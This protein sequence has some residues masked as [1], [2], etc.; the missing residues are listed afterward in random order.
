MAIS[1]SA[2]RAGQAYVELLVKDSAFL[3]GLNRA[4]SALKRLGARLNKIGQAASRAGKDLIKMGVLG[5]TPI[6]FAVRRFAQFDD[7]MRE[8]QAVTQATGEDFEKLTALAKELGRTTSFTAV[9]VAAGMAEMGRMGFTATEILEGIPH[10][11]NLARATTTEVGEAAEIAGA[12]LRG[13]GLDASQ[14]A[15]VADVLTTAANKSAQRLEDIGE[16][17]KYVAP[18]AITA[19]ASIEDTAAALAV[20]ANYGVRGTIAGT[21]LRNAYIRLTETKGREFLEQMGIAATN[22]DGSLRKLTDILLDLGDATANLPNADRIA[23]FAN[24]LG[25]RALIGGL[26][27]GISRKKLEEMV[28]IFTKTKDAARKT[29]EEM[30]RG[31]GGAIRRFL[32]AFEGLG[33]AVGDAMDKVLQSV[34]K[35]LTGTLGIITKFVNENQSL[36]VALGLGFVSAIALGAGLVVLGYAFIGLGGIVTTVAATFAAIASVIGFMLTP[37]GA[38]TVGFAYLGYQVIKETGVIGEASDHLGTKFDQLKMTAFRSFEGIKSALSSG[39]FKAAAEIAMLGMEVAW[40]EGTKELRDTWTGFTLDINAFFLDSLYSIQIG[41][42]KFGQFFDNFWAKTIARF[43]TDWNDANNAVAKGWTYVLSLLD[44]SIDVEAV[45]KRLDR[46]AQ[47]S[48]ENIYAEFDK[49]AAENESNLKALEKERRN[50]LAAL[51]LDADK[52]IKDRVS[53]LKLA[54]DKLRVAVYEA[55][56]KEAQRQKDLEV[57]APEFEPPKLP[58][59]AGALK[60][61]R[62]TETVGTFSA[63]QA[64]AIAG[65]GILGNQLLDENKKQTTKL[66]AI[67]R[68]TDDLEG[69]LA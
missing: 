24:L 25:A 42:V 39:D 69:G 14:M 11:M 43:K 46:E 19:G 31:I 12:S 28:A 59:F 66:E 65:G 23:I 33:L 13:F 10:V 5:A 22:S 29:A 63:T 20:L 47:R 3:K 52:E 62:E 15:R 57:E 6:F 26:R 9:Q 35:S 48:N 1:A 36:V 18:V 49:N 8:V 17:M 21:A 27:I 38:L 7:K 32:S 2:V 30:D 68:N 40:L 60:R 16:A 64:A 41:L 56:T 53:A 37:V 61:V 34:G 44:D 58:D 50:A 45:N 4:I 54:K 67:E 55:N 51:A